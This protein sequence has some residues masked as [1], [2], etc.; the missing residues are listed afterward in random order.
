VD[1]RRAVEQDA[2]AMAEV[3]AV[4]APEDT[5]GA[6]PPVDV[7]TR[8]AGFRDLLAGDGAAWVLD[9]GG[10]VQ[11]YLSLT[12]RTRGVF[13]L[14]M[15][16]V[17]AGRGRGGGR[18]LVEAALAFARAGGAHKVDLEVW[19]DNARAI[20]LYAA[21]GFVVEGLRDRHYLRADGTLRSSLIMARRLD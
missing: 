9:D 10:V 8:A 6:Q 2:A 7:V 17:A 13:G 4:V 19:P 15:A 3:I 12:P 16:I 14:G 11:G 1:V 21:T 20:A 18:A 5:L